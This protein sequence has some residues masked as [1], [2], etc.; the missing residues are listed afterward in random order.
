MIFL[1]INPSPADQPFAGGVGRHGAVGQHKP[2]DTIL[3]ELG[4]HVQ[5]PAVVGVAG[6][7]HFITTPAWIINQ[8]I[9]ATPFLEVEG[10]IGH[11]EVGLQIFVLILEEGISRNLT[12]IAGDA[13]NGQVHLRQLVGGAGVFLPVDGDVLLAALVILDKLDRLYEHAA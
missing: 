11:D 12:Q 7:R 10:R 8:F 2:R 5:Y 13:A 3:R 9:V 1:R 6:W 4:N